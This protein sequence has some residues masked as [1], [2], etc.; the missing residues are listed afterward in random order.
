VFHDTIRANIQFGRDGVSDAMISE[1]SRLARADEFIIQFP[2]GYDTVV[3]ERGTQISGGQRQRIAL[4][5]ALVRD[6][7]ILILDEATNALD[8]LTEA[9]LQQS[10]KSFAAART[11][12]TITHRMDAVLGADLLLVVEDGRIVESGPPQKLVGKGGAFARLYQSS[13]RAGATPTAASHETAA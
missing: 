1:A 2:A 8:T 6:P 12:I 13:S 3:G 11:V 7:D 5:R 10:L 4:A 9:T